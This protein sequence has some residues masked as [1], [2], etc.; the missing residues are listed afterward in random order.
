VN[1]SEVSEHN[2]GIPDKVEIVIYFKL[3][4]LI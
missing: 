1:S 3:I 2:A 4:V